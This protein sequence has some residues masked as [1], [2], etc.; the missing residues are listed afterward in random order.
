MYRFGRG[1]AACR[2]F[3]GAYVLQGYSQLAYRSFGLYSAHLL[4]S[5]LQKY[6]TLVLLLV[7]AVF[8]PRVASRLF[9]DP[10]L[11][12]VQ[13]PYFFH[14][15]AGSCNTDVHKRSLPIGVVAIRVG[16]IAHEFQSSLAR[17]KRGTAPRFRGHDGAVLWCRL[18]FCRSCPRCFLAASLLKR[19]TP[20]KH[21]NA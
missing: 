6:Q 8:F 9:L 21:E 2:V 1:D 14:L 12:P 19:E 11:R 15:H 3:R 20:H 5:G 10:C 4:F 7:Q 13:R 16:Y 18:C 17:N